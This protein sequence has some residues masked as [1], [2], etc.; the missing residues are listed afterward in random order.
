MLEPCPFCGFEF[1]QDLLGAY[2]CPNFEG[3]GLEGDE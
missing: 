2:G 1:D 3:E